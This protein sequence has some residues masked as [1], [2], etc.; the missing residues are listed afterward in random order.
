M[1]WFLHGCPACGGDLHEDPEAEGW[2]ECFLCSRTFLRNELPTEAQ[3]HLE[4]VATANQ[5]SITP[6]REPVEP[7]AA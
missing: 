3:R 2:V 1:K 4:L 7:V 6:G 5:D